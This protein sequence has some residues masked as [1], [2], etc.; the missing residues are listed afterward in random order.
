LKGSQFKLFMRFVK[1]LFPYWKKET[2]ILILGGVSVLLS[3]VNPYLAKLVV[4]KAFD[5]KNLRVFVILVLIGAAVFILNGLISALKNYLNK[6]VSIKVNFDLNKTVFKHLETL[7]LDHFRNKSTSEYFY[8]I[9]YDIDR[10][11]DFIKN[12]PPQIVATFPK[13]FFILIIVMRLN[14]QMAIFSVVLA[15]LLYLPHYYLIRIMKKVW[16]DLI[17]NSEFIFKHLHGVFSRIYLVKAFAK[18]KYETRDYLKKKIMNIR[19]NLKNA[20]LGI[21]S[22]LAGSAVNKIAIGLITFFGGYQVIRGQMTLGSLTAIML[23]IGQLISLES[24]FAMFFQ[25]TALGLVSCRRIEK[26]LDEKPKIFEIKQTHNAVFKNGEIVFR[27]VSLGY[28]QQEPILSNISFNI[29]GGSCIVLIGPS[30]CGK[31]TILNLILRLYEPWAGDILIDG[32]N[33]KN[34]PFS[35]LREQI[36]VALQEPFLFNDTIENN[37]RYGKPDA[38]EQEI[39]ECAKI[40]GV[41]KF[42]T[43]LPGKY[44]FVTGESACRLS[45]GQKQKIAIARAL[46]KK[47]KIFILDEAMSSMDLASEERIITGIK[48][49]PEIHTIIAV[50]HRLSTVLRADKVYSL[51][52]PDEIIIGK[53]EELFKKREDLRDLFAAQKFVFNEHKRA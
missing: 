5:N 2:A 12:T 4:D 49:I 13:L 20:R 10:V 47:P 38:S 14:W 31:T 23:Y 22:D 29:K 3:L 26:I 51:I 1:Y 36:G 52:K 16:Q 48:Q 15:P 27:D 46:I 30:G 24:I 33:I 40:C 45:E 41:D 25:D 21:V 18:E 17:K 8:N 28:R 34:L 44:Q 39:M 11:S 37:I 7:D 32:Y 35:V 43:G 9:S 50:S 19:I 6:Q 42:T 53:A